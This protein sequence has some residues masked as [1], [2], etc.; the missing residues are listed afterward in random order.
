MQVLMDSGSAT[1]EERASCFGDRMVIHDEISLPVLPSSIAECCG[2]MDEDDSVWSRSTRVASMSWDWDEPPLNHFHVPSPTSGRYRGRAESY[3]SSSSSA[4]PF[5]RPTSLSFGA[6]ESARPEYSSPHSPGFVF[7]ED[8]E[9]DELEGLLDED[10]T[11]PVATDIVSRRHRGG[12]PFQQ[13]GLPGDQ[14]KD[15][16]RPV[17]VSEGEFDYQGIPWPRFSISRTDYRTKRVR[18]YSN[19][20]NVNWTAQLEMKR[21]FDLSKVRRVRNDMFYFNETFR[22]VN[23]TIDHFQLRHL[24]WN[25]SNTASYLVSNSSLYE[26]NKKT[27]AMRRIQSCNPQQLA[28]CHVDHGLAATGSFDS[29]VKITRLS[30]SSQILA[31]KVSTDPNS[32]TNH[33]VISDASNIVVANNDS[34]VSEITLEEGGR[35]TSRHKWSTAVNHASVSPNGSLLC[36]S[37][38]KCEISLM[39]RRTGEIVMDLEG[40]LDFSFCSSWRGDW[41]VSTGSQDGTCRIWDLRKTG[42]GSVACLGSLLGAIRCCKFSP[43]GRYLAVSEPADFVHV[44][45]VTS[46]LREVQLLD[47]FGNIG[48]I[49][50]TPDSSKLSISLADTMFGC[51]VDF[52]VSSLPLNTA[53]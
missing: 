37:G 43:D 12:F 34:H 47:F 41:T 20:N 23:P 8:V 44:H 18:E 31:I 17:D 21:R 9:G 5:C 27:R 35:I 26:F 19:Y 16:I 22:T 14:N 30:D 29:E 2:R 39:E 15:V 4:P 50:F 52:Q 36:L 6:G 3:C 7:R 46:G 51:L 40:H 11:R 42:H 45:D 33:V 25:T 10:S 32:I 49:A 13:R 24:L 28:S 48:G 38:D 53:K 1:D